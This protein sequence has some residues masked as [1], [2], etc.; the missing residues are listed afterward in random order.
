MQTPF[1]IAK[2]RT[3]LLLDHPFFGTAAMHVDLIA[4]STIPT[5]STNGVWVRYNPAFMA[6]LTASEQVFVLA[7]EIDHNLLRHTYRREGRDPEDWNIACDYVVNAQLVKSGFTPPANILLDPQYDGMFAEQVYSKRRNAPPEEEQEGP[8]EEKEESESENQ[9]DSGEGDPDG[10][11]AQEGE[12]TPG[13]GESGE[14]DEGDGEEGGDGQGESADESSA[15]PGAGKSVMGDCPTGDFVDGPVSR[16]EPGDLTENDWEIIAE[17]AALAASAAGTLPGCMARALQRAKESQVDWLAEL[18]PF[19]VNTLASEEVSWAFPNRRLI[20]QEIYLPGRIKENVGILVY[21]VD[22][23]GSV[24]QELFDTFSSELTAVLRE[25]R[26]EK[27]IVLCVDTAVRAVY[28]FTPDDDFEVK[29]EMTGGGGTA[30]QPVFDYIEENYL[31][32][33]AVVYLTDLDGPSPVEPRYP[34][35]WVTPLWSSFPAPF[36]SLIQLP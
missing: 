16:E 11:E 8:P 25:V 15:E 20:S 14:G 35:L 32:P 18:R 33:L 26:P 5:A 10:E 29:L 24:T 22:V 7:H 31:D 1:D 23:S 36:G 30:F 19:I 12:D 3:R 27:L 17:E 9:G 21:G 28:E 2:V 34:V 6:N 4:D 13:D